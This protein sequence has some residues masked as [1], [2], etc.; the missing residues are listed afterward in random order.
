M[1]SHSTDG[2]P[3]CTVGQG[4]VTQNNLKKLKLLP[5][6]DAAQASDCL[7]TQRGYTSGQSVFSGTLDSQSI[8]LG[9][10]GGN[11]TAK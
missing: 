8:W 7:I 5:M 1:R 11:V 10:G 3:Q 9:V 6:Q 4:G 2:K